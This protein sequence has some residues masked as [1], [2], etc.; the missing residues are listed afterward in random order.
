MNR[1]YY[2]ETAETRHELRK[3][4]KGPPAYLLG[5]RTLVNIPEIY[6][7]HVRKT[8]ILEGPGCWCRR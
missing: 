6:L 5:V 7:M 3:G 1:M 4:A 8:E 2:T